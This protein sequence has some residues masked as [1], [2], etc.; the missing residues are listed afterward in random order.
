MPFS[1]ICCERRSFL[2][3]VHSSQH[4]FK[5]ILTDRNSPSDVEKM[6]PRKIKRKQRSTLPTK[7]K[8]MLYEPFEGL[9]I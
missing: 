5:T 7:V 2:K 6:W 8:R 1:E 9:S 4:T 3:L